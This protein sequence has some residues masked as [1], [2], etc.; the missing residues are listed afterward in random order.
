MSG[1]IA[2]T[3]DQYVEVLRMQ[4][5]PDAG[6]LLCEYNHGFRALTKPFDVRLDKSGL[7]VYDFTQRGKH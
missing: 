4:F 3:S 1:H 2:T 5:S 7:R 6:Q